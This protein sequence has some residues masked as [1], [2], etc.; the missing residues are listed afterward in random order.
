MSRAL[1]FVDVTEIKDNVDVIVV[2]P[3]P[4]MLVE[5]E[6]VVVDTPPPPNE[7]GS[8]LLVLAVPSAV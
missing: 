2:D 6:A 3:V 5:G 7:N 1:R 8:A 4:P